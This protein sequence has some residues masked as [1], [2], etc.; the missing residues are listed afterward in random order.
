M[1]FAVVLGLGYGGF[2][3]NLPTVLA[4][5]YGPGLVGRELGRQYVAVAIGAAVG[6][7]ALAL[8]TDSARSYVPVEVSLLVCGLVAAGLLVPLATSARTERRKGMT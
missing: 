7:E 6:P 2:I 8:L 4:E 5:L 1:V 3:T